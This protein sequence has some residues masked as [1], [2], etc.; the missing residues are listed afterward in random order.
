MLAPFRSI[1]ARARPRR[2]RWRLPIAVALGTLVF[3]GVVALVS[4]II[5]RD[6]FLD[7]LEDE[8]ARQARQLAATLSQLNGGPAGANQAH[9]L[10]DAESLQQFIHEVGLAASA[11]I[12]LIDKTG[13]VLADSEANPATLENHANRP[14]VK[15]ALAGYEARERRRSRTLGIE[16]VYVA[17]PLPRSEAPWSEGAIRVAQPAARIDNMLAASWRIPLFVWA[18]LLIPMVIAAYLVS[19]SI[20]N[21]LARLQLMTSRVAAGDLGYRTTISRDDELGELAQAFNDMAAQLQDREQ[22]L[23]AETERSAKILEAMNEGVLVVDEQGRIL[24]ANPAAQ[25]LLG[26]DLDESAGKPLVLVARSFPAGDLAE[27]AWQAG[28]PISQTVELTP[29]RTLAAEVIPLVYPEKG[30]TA[31]PRRPSRGHTLFVLRD[32]TEQRRVEQMRR[33]FVTNVSHELKTPLAGL[34]LLAQTLATCIRE[35][36]TTA[37]RFV[38]RLT[39]EVQRLNNL[40]SDLLVLS[41]L[42]EPTPTE[43]D[44]FKPVDLALTVAEVVEEMRSLAEAKRHEL[45]ASLPDTLL[46][47]GEE[48]SLRA[49][50]KNLLDNAIRYTEPGGHIRVSLDTETDNAGRSW[51]VLSVQDDGIGIPAAEQQRVFERFYRVDKARSRETGG[52]GLGLS[53]VR[54]AAERHKGRVEVKSTVGVGSTFTVFLPLS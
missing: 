41:R 24:R 26:F 35:D 1:L 49:I 7:R 17:L 31:T 10:Y 3:A 25:A 38:E 6:V 23:R 19:R 4:A 47:N 21:P 53:I 45:T 44:V 9:P 16:E 18:A 14:E 52:T 27:R 32:E 30:Q 13:M 39:A 2:L 43:P 11:R 46:I 54:H 42:E 34:S 40:V 12:T 48:P 36:P 8:M 15:Q 37:E 50:I 29:N 33:D 5:L 22:E 20:V 28:K 51:G